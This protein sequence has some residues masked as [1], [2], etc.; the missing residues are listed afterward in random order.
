M[1]WVTKKNQTAN[2]EREWFIFTRRDDVRRDP[3]THRL[4]ADHEPV[5]FQLPVL[6]D[7]FDHGPKT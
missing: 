4:A 5:V 2:V 7:R 6:C 3:S 1:Q